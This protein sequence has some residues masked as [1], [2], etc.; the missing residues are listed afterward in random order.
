MSTTVAPVAATTTGA[1]PAV[2]TAMAT[3][4][5]SFAYLNR[6]KKAVFYSENGFFGYG[7]YPGSSVPSPVAGRPRADE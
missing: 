3:A 7:P 1:A 2:G 5:S 6:A 4:A